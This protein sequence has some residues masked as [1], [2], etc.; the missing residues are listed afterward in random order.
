MSNPAPKDKR[1]ERMGNAPIFGLIMKMSVPTMFSMIVQALYNVVDSMFVS[2]Y[3]KSALTAVSL[4]FPM[5]LLLIGF[6]VGTAIG[7][8]SLISRRLGEG[9]HEEAN[10]AAT[11]S[12]MLSV[13]TWVLFAAVGLIFSSSIIGAYTDNPKVLNAGTQYLSTVYIFS[14]GIIIE[15]GIE[16]LLQ[17]T[18]NSVFPML[19]QLSGA[20]INTILDPIF[21]FGL[22]P[23]PSMGALGAAIATVIGQIASMIFALIVLFVRKN[24]IKISFRYLKK[25]E[26]HIIKDIYAVGFP[27]IVMQSISSAMLLGLNGILAG[28]SETYVDVLG[29]YFKLQSF[30][31]MPVFGLTHGVMPIMGYNYG[32]GNKK[33]LLTTLKYGILIAIAVMAAG[34]L[35]FQLIPDK[36][37]GMFNA[38]PEMFE[39]GIPAL[40]TISLCFVLAAIG[41]M[42][43]TLF[44]ATGKG[45]RSML[46]SLLRQLGVILPAAYMLSQISSG[47]VWWAFPIAEGVALIVALLFYINLYKK[48]I[49]DLSPQAARRASAPVSALKT[50]NEQ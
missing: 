8:N 44:Q 11:Y 50:T 16:K 18:G 35:A 19:F 38:Y 1:L 25:P 12:L 27:S 22:G 6:G 46:T 24:P 5:Q 32:A 9:R 49:R 39:V 20:V 21:I 34:M 31:F 43:S 15:V 26:M 41:I 37:L 7:V 29:V 13:L 40:K 45:L 23:I 2:H 10:K 42:I 4:A 30:V 28:I 14:F 33:R 47:L 17:S 3:D 48:N 36:L